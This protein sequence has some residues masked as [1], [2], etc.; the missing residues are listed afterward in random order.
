MVK[1]LVLVL[2]RRALIRQIPFE[3]RE[4]LVRILQS[5]YA[6]M[7]RKQQNRFSHKKLICYTVG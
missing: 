3:I 5:D 4:S 6:C 7:T 1:L 2:E